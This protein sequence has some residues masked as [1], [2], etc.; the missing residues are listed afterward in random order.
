MVLSQVHPMEQPLLVVEVDFHWGALG[1]WAWEAVEEPAKEAGSVELAVALAL[2][3]VG[4]VAPLSAR[5]G[6]AGLV[7]AALVVA[8]WVQDVASASEAQSLA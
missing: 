5:L 6:R 1:H 4:W 8:M 3:V 7:L 2:E